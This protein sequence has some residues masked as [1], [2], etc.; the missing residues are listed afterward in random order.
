MG[1]FEKLAVLTVLF[2]SAIVLAVSLNEEEEPVP[3][4][5]P[6]GETSRELAQTDPPA[7]PVETGRE[8]P[9]TTDGRGFLLSSEV[10]PSGPATPT[11]AAPGKP[12]PE[13]SAGGKPRILRTTTGLRPSGM[14]DFMVYEA[15]EGDTWSSLARRFYDDLRRVSLLR[16]ANEELEAPRPGEGIL[17]PVFDLARE[18]GTRAAFVPVERT[19]GAAESLKSVATYTVKD[20]DNLSSISAV[21]YGTPNRW[22]EIY[23]ANRGVLENPD[24]LDVG[25]VLTIPR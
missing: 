2:L 20:G 1:N 19:A 4:A 25:M 3:G 18:G 22:E 5:G 6:L 12:R 14:E 21:V 16:V 7:V 17:V 11:G 24:W 15:V 23:K 8:G 9:A 13:V 10:K